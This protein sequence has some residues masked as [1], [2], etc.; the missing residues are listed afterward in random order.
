MCFT[1]T[2]TVDPEPVGV[3]SVPTQSV[4]SD[5]AIAGIT[6]STSN[7]MDGSTTYAWT[8]DNTTDVT[9]I[10]NSGTTDITGVLTNLTGVSQDVI[11]TIIP[12]SGSCVGNAFTATVTVDPEPVGVASVPTQSVCSDIAIAGITLSTSNSM[13]GSTTYAWTRDNTTDVTGI[14]NSGTTDITGVLTNL[15]GVSQDVIFTIIP[16]SGSCVGNA[17]TATVTVDPEPVGVASV[18]TQSVCSDIAIAGITLS[19]SNSMDGSTTYAWTRDNTTDVT[20]IANSGTTDITGVLTEPDRSLPGRDLYDYP[21]Q[22][23][24]CGQCFYRHRYRRSRAGGCGK[25]TNSECLFRYSH[26]RYY[27]IDQQ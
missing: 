22:W 6:L 16:T 20:G 9:G 1:A 4:C 8:R 7:S 26:S 21:H 3:A 10:A 5:I 24:L 25:C 12:T 13:D 23:Q 17:F 15:T 19:T 27:F 2:V 11:F 14:A 18:P